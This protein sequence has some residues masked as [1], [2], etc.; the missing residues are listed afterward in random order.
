MKKDVKELVGQCFVCQ[1][2][3]YSTE[4]SYGLL[5]PTELPKRVWEDIAM[6]FITNLPRSKGYT[7]VFVVVNRYLKYAHFGLLPTT[8]MASQVAALFCLMAI[9]LHGVPRSIISDRDPLFTS[10]FW[11]KIF[12]VMGTKLRMSTTYHPQTDGQTE[13][14]NRCLEQYLRAF[15]ADKRS[16]W[17]TYLGWAEYHYNT[18]HHL[19]IG[20]SPFEVVYGRPPPSIPAYI[21]GTSSIPA[22]EVMLITRDEVLRKL[23]QHLLHSQQRM[24]QYADKERQDRHFQVG[25]FV[26]VKLQPYR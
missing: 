3:K 25:D 10:K 26:L 24:K 14:L 13:V 5:H 7:A 2:V 22:G 9:C 15:A 4:K 19:A 16:L 18:S 8:Y 12:E 17:A 1:I 21:R 23:R 20:T 11:R 6:D